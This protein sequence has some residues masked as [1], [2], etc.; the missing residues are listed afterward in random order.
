MEADRSRVVKSVVTYSL[1]PPTKCVLVLSDYMCSKTRV[2]FCGWLGS[3][4]QVFR[5]T[6]PTTLARLEINE[7]TF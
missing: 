2:S 1:D 5:F 7:K 3:I 4:P 6:H